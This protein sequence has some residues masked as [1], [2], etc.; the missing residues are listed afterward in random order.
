VGRLPPV[1]VCLLALEI[2][3]GIRAAGVQGPGA[4]FSQRAQRAARGKVRE[5]Q[6]RSAAQAV[7]LHAADRRPQSKGQKANR[8]FGSPWRADQ[9]RR[10]RFR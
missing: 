5:P 8:K 2:K 3:T 4:E 9:Q 1:L 6:A 7:A 10:R